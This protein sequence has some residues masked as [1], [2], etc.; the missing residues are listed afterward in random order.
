MSIED[1]T[2]EEL[3]ERAQAGEEEAFTCLYR[4]R[5]AGVYRFAL[6]M[7]GSAAIAED[8]TQEVFLA[9]LREGR[10]YSPKRG[11]VAGYLL[12]ISR[13]QVLRRLERDG[14]QAAATPSDEPV[15]SA[16]GPLD[17]LARDQSIQAIRSA[18]LGLPARYREVVALCDLEE[19]RYEEAAAALGCAVGTVRSR[20]HRAHGLLARKLCQRG[21]DY[22]QSGFSRV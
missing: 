5:Q 22:E 17:E 12:G 13:N 15:S 14:P 18:V 8:V 20:L 3:F 21:V 7:S 4:R 9:L 1:L 10:R 16:K 2:D 6:R 11:S 19:M